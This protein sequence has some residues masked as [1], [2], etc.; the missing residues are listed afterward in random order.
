MLG[1]EFP[2]PVVSGDEL[3]KQVIA[4]ATLQPIVPIAELLRIQH[5]GKLLQVSKRHGAVEP[6]AEP[7]SFRFA[8]GFGRMDQP[9]IV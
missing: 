2:H 6:H 1:A 3:A 5:T 4:I 8:C 7:V 9:A